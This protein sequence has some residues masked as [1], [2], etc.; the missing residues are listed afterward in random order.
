M[1]GS[2]LTHDGCKADRPSVIVVGGEALVDLIVR[3][4]G[5]IDA[6]PGGGP[7]NAVRTAAR[8]GA[9]TRFLGRLSADGF[10][11]LLADTLADDAVDLVA[12]E[13]TDAPTTLAVARLD[14]RGGASYSF[15]LDGTSAT[16][17]EPSHVAPGA[18]D[19]CDA[20][21]VGGLALALEPIASTLA[22]ILAT[23]PERT[24]VV[25]DPNCRSQTAGDLPAYRRRLGSFIAKADIV[26][27]SV[28]DLALLRPTMPPLAAAREFLAEAARVVLVTRGGD[29][30]TVVASGGDVTVPVPQ[31]EIVDTVG[32]GDAFGAA[33]TAWWCHHGLGR[34]GLGDLA[35]LREAAAAAAW[36]AVDTCTRTG[37]DPPRLADWPGRRPS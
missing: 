34:D 27:A 29:A 23:R 4:D 8:L 24:L 7:F 21:F 28:D 14:D 17:L 1:L 26:K 11:D 3:P 22:G 37:A 32:A 25:V 16:Q 31:V 2:L 13:R 12:P 20:F 33:F 6:K 30:V 10:G 36:V 18:L 9:E 35:T 19:D 15:Y 5:T